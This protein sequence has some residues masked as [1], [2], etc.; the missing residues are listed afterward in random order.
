[1]LNAMK[2]SLLTPLRLGDYELKNRVVM[3]PLTRMRANADLSPVDLNAVYYR[4]R[5]SAGLII[6]EASQ[7]SPQGQ[8]Y[9]L[10]P[11]IYSEQQVAGWKKV[12]EA[13]HNE[14]GRIFIQLWHVGRISHS[15][16]HPGDGLPVAPSAVKP[17]GMTFTGT[18]E[19][20]PFETPRAL[21]T[22][23]VKQI[24]KDYRKAAVNAVKA[25][26]DGVE[27]H[28]ANGYLLNQFLHAKTNKRTDEYGGSIENRARIVLEV[29]D[30][31]VEVLGPGKVGIRLSPF[32][33]SGDIY[34]PESYPVYPYLLDKIA[35]YNLAYVHLIRARETDVNDQ[36]ALDQEKELWKAY[37]GTVI[38]ADGFT[39]ETARQYVDERLADAVAFGR[40]F[41]ANPDLP[42][43]I[44]KDRDLNPYDRDTF[45]GGGEKGYTDY[46]FLDAGR[47]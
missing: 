41:I 12:T 10:T 36:S 40:L 23:E 4:Q 44:E 47:A 9:P 15:S 37:P 2:N 22:S 13:V 6:T 28:S 19:Q 30:V 46:P 31:L 45:Y 32:T 35:A 43:R 1:M 16:L 24:V 8:G 42:R 39:P 34:D 25:G 18:W 33:M 5:A 38:A 17:E 29:L 3:A 27:L 14:G 11:G 21:E 7:I 26:F 20:V